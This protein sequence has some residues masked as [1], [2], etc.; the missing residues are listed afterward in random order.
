MK[1]LVT[2]ATG[3]VGRNV[4]VS[5]ERVGHKVVGVGRSRL[6]LLNPAAVETFLE[7]ERVEGLVHLAWDT[8][9][10]A[11][12]E[13][14][15]NL[16]WAAAS[17]FL[18]ESFAR[19]GGQRAVVAGTSAEYQWGGDADL[20]ETCSS[21]RSASLYGVSKDSLRRLLE[22]WSPR[23]GVSLGWARIF[24]PFGP[25][26]KSERLIPRLI[27]RLQE[28][29]RIPFDSGSLIR[30]FLHVVELGD[31]FAALFDSEVQGAVNLASGEALTIREV[32]TIIGEVL[33]RLNQIEFNTLTDPEGQAPRIVASVERLRNEVNWCPSLTTRKRLA[34]TCEWWVN[35]NELPSHL[36]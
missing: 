7:A 26:E 8:T 1:V 16:K 4:T 2:G 23:A 9:P 10:G 5:L 22:F 32:V 33:G 6:D 34:E 3:F 12:W 28:G 27:S 15:E 14:P 24:C 13:T 18:L 36:I 31:A 20:D 25:H 30:D 35:H 21:L 11:Y 29:E 17:L 19:H